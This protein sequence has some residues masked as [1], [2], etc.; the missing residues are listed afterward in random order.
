MNN[1]IKHLP[2][3]DFEVEKFDFQKWWN[4]EYKPKKPHFKFKIHKTHRWKYWFCAGLNIQ[5]YPNSKPKYIK[6]IN[7][8]DTLE[9]ALNE[10]S[11]NS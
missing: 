10:H 11:R 9:E 4:E 6:G 3:G 5:C 1:T 8:F 7:P 2:N